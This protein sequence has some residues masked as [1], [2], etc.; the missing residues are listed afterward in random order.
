MRQALVRKLVRW[1]VLT[2][3]DRRLLGA[4]PGRIQG[5]MRGDRPL[6]GVD[7][8]TCTLL[9]LEGWAAEY[10]DTPSGRRVIVEYLL[11]G[12]FRLSSPH[13]DRG[14]DM[15][16]LSQGIVQMVPQE[17]IRTLQQSE[18]IRRAL[19]WTESV[20]SATQAEWLVNIGAR[21]AYAR[22]AHLLCELAVR[23]N[24]IDMLD[25]NICE[26]PL[27]Q[28]DLAASLAMSNVHLNLA[29]QRLRAARLVDISAR[30]L[31]ILKRAELE[32]IAGF[33]DSYLLR[34][35]T[36]LPDRR[37]HSELP[38]GQTERRRAD[39]WR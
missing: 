19:E 17:A 27:T 3:E 1:I 36:A 11:P 10:K 39:A 5:F 37:R 15:M 13:R 38:P 20:R 31:I 30:R 22:L 16:M 25:G 14:L 29:L 33:D 8:T 23:M 32:A 4:L 28:I 12:D 35:P 9:M 34:W 6:A 24:S 21:K 26:L 7:P 2:D 18:A